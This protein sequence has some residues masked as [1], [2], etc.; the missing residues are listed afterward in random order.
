V[1]TFELPERSLSSSQNELWRARKT[2][3]ERRSWQPSGDGWC[4]KPGRARKSA[5]P[6]TS[7]STSRRRP[8]T[9]LS[10]VLDVQTGTSGA[11]PRARN[12]HAGSGRERA[13][14][15]QRG[16]GERRGGLGLSVGLCFFVCP[17]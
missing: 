2:A 16:S 17:L 11:S 13:L 12:A 8:R 14:E 7:R 1:S 4:F 5:L 10:T 3:S 6:S 15:R 9:S